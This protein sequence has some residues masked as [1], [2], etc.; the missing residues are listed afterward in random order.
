MADSPSLPGLEV[1]PRQAVVRAAW[2][3]AATSFGEA[4]LWHRWEAVEAYATWRNTVDRSFALVDT[5]ASRQVRALVPLRLVRGRPP[6]RRLLGRLESTGGPAY[7]P[8]LTAGERRNA[9]RAVGDE[10]RRIAR[11]DRAWRIDLALPPLAPAYSADRRPSVNP[12][13]MLGCTEA[14]TQSWIVDLRGHD[15]AS[16]W[17]HV[18]QRVRKAV[19][20]A[21]RDGVTMRDMIS[22]DLD[23][24]LRLHA[25]NAARAGIEAR[26]DAYFRAIFSRFLPSGLAFGL[27]ASDAAGVPLAMHV[28]AVDKGAALYWTVASTDAALAA[29]ANDLV[30]WEAML[31]FLAR[32]LE[33]YE[34]GE[35]F[36]GMRDGKLKRISDFKKGFG[37]ALQPYHRGA[38]VARPVVAALR[39][40]ARALI[41][42]TP[43]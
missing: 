8:D 4:W 35:A 13:I 33:R 37:G 40:L 29:G 3:A 11:A 19:N 9:E 7:A 21:R 23:S 39:D 14:S 6:F 24:Y 12:L 18:D 31:R 1:Q 36:P 32:G 41:A 38:I 28:F 17:R 20:R 26:P 30:Q 25:A 2:D 15:E 34:T 27:C 22:G 10:L 16:L 5:S 43:A 42:R